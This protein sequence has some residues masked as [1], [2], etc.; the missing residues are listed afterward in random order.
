MLSLKQKKVVR[1]VWKDEWEVH[2]VT[3]Q[4][5]FQER[6][7]TDEA[8]VDGFVSRAQ[9]LE[10]AI[11]LQHEL[12]LS[13]KQEQ[14]ALQ[15]A[16]EQLNARFLRVCGINAPV[17]P[18][19]FIS[20]DDVE[21]D[22]WNIMAS[23]RRIHEGKWRK[24]SAMIEPRREGF[25]IVPSA[26]SKWYKQSHPNLIKLF[27]ACHIGSS[28][29]L[30]YEVMPEG[31]P[32]NEFV[33]DKPSRSSTW[34]CLYK[35]ALGLQHLHLRNVIHG[36]LRSEN[37]IVGSN[38]VTKLCGI[39]ESMYK[40]H[41]EKRET[42]NWI[43]PEQ[44][45]LSTRGLGMSSVS[46][47]ADIYAFGMCIWE[48]LTLELPWQS[49]DYRRID[50]KLRNGELP[51]RSAGTSDLEW[52]LITKMCATEPSAR[53]SITYVV[54]KLKQLVRDSE[55]IRQIDFGKARSTR[56]DITGVRNLHDL[57]RSDLTSTFS[58]PYCVVCVAFSEPDRFRGGDRLCRVWRH[59][60]KHAPKGRVQVCAA[61]RARPVD[62]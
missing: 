30:V 5:H 10:T 8:L 61:P 49:D 18:E 42:L 16:L 7:I 22:D 15:N 35:A 60:S 24:T 31:K 1:R 59:H 45:Q 50:E 37:I 9:K 2:Q 4:R 3:L 46:I 57:A 14:P 20:R 11:L 38:S 47:P 17:A 23:M 53:V 51:A 29:F 54:D 32:L 39:G 33:K 28:Q 25:K 36:S 12:R 44:A 43:T 62:D 56:S 27:G 13:S 21:F 34:N 26:V 58:L 6:F 40:L 55:Q 19:W 41:S 52:D 48:A